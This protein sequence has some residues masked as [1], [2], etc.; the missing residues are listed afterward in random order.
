MFNIYEFSRTM[1][2][3]SKSIMNADITHEDTHVDISVI[4]P[5]YNRAQK[6]EETV[7][8]VEASAQGMTCEVLLVDDNSQ[9]LTP[10]V[11]SRL[12]ATY[13]N[14]RYFRN[15]FNRGPAAARNRAIVEARGDLIFFTD[16]DCIVPSD[17]LSSFKRH[18]DENP[19]V[20]GAGGILRALTD[21]WIS[22]IERCKDSVL[23]IKMNSQQTGRQGI[24]VGFTNNLAYRKSVFEK[25][26]LFNE[27]FKVPAG[28]DVEFIDR[29]TQFFDV[30]FLPITVIH[31]HDY[32][33]D[34]LVGTLYKQGM[35][36]L[37]PQN[38]ALRYLLLPFLAPLLLWHI[39]HKIVCYRKRHR[40]QAQKTH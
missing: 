12:S 10:S 4:I 15:D 36:R 1:V 8:S 3:A 35:N 24:P 32:S 19:N 28:E 40:T 33:P 26:G 2:L 38:K 7:K 9:D 11:A 39:P 5:T 13:G 23:K 34:Y 25:V 6:L 22:W 17:W 37:P 31:N 29:V 20:Y 18:F 27:H 16:D 14:I 30:S 21:N